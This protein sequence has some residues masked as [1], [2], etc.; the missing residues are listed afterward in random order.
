MKTLYALLLCIPLVCWLAPTTAQAQSYDFDGLTSGSTGNLANGWIASPTAG[1][2]W[3]AFTG[4]TPSIGTGPSFDHT[5]GTGVY[6]HVEADLGAVGNLATVESPNINLAG[7]SEPRMRFWYH[8][9]G[10]SMGGLFIDVFSGGAW[11][12]NI[13]SVPG[14]VQTSVL[15]PWLE[16]QVNLTA[17]AGT[18]IKV[19]FRAVRGATLS[20]DMAVD[21]VSFVEA[22]DYDAVAEN[23]VVSMPYH[24]IPLDQAQAISFDGDVLNLGFNTLSS[25]TGTVNVPSATFTTNDNVSNLLTETTQAF[26]FSSSFTPTATGLYNAEFIVSASQND[27]IAY[28][29]TTFHEFAVS[30]SVYARE[31]GDWTGGIGFTGAT[32]FFGQSFEM[33]TDDTLT[34]ISVNLQSP[35]AG[36]SIR[37]IIYDFST[38]LPTTGL[39]TTDFLVIPSAIPNWYEIYFPCDIPLPAGQ[40]FVAVQQV[41]TNNLGFGFSTEYYELGTTFFSVNGT[42]WSTF[43]SAGFEVTLGL[44]LNLGNPIGGVFTFDIGPD[45]TYCPGTGINLLLDAFELGATYSWNT[46]SSAQI[47]N[48]DTAGQYI[49]TV[50]KCGLNR[51]DTV[52]VTELPSPQVN[53][54]SDTAYCQGENFSLSFDYSSVAGAS[55]V[56]TGG[57]MSPT[58]TIT[59]AG[60]YS[61]TGTLGTCVESD[62]IIV[63]EFDTLIPIEL[64]PDSFYCEGVVLFTTLDATSPGVTYNWSTGSTAPT[65]NVASPGTYTVTI[66]LGGLCADSM[67]DSIAFTEVPLPVVGLV[68]TFFCTGGGDVVLDPGSGFSQYNWSTGDTTPTIRVNAVGTYRVTVSDQFGCTDD[69]G[70]S[71]TTRPGIVVNLGPDTGFYQPITLD[72]GTGYSGYLWSTGDTTQTTVA[73]STGTYWVQVTS[74]DGCTATDTIEVTVAVGID[75]LEVTGWNLY[76]NPNAGQFFLE[77]TGMSRLIQLDVYSVTGAHVLGRELDVYGGERVAIELPQATPGMY[78]LHV[79]EGNSVVVHRFIVK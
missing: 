38:G 42:A 75:E 55:Y 58:Y 40:Y 72:A 51:L 22:P 29:D 44:R 50:S 3:Q 77:N 56:W 21:D 79:R 54:G 64:G 7:F 31:R 74:S 34:S 46:G 11:I 76:P 27:T 26:A 68:D 19:R 14:S 8:K 41:N 70:S 60:V 57:V 63:Q 17:Y 37:F 59:S 66:T 52:V 43:E 39:D 1:Y 16:K 13:D 23:F 49:V 71:V 47:L 12:Q 61:V 2:R 24:T 20:G 15:D 18:T 33:F 32:G 48:V 69:G 10:T 28:N 36:D 6:L 4:A 45:T 25:V 30:D 67:I 53:L 78:L 73:N 65:Q 35:T 62:Q 9:V 5:T